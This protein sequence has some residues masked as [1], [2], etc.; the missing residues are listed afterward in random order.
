VT[1]SRGAG[2]WQREATFG[3]FASVTTRVETGTFVG[4]EA[5]YLRRYEGLGLDPFAG[6][7]LFVGPTMFVRLSKALA[8][9]G[10][11]D[12]QVAGRAVAVPGALDLTH[13]ERH[14]ATL[15]LEY[16]F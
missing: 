8:I 2:V 14:Q 13:F 9:S 1:R 4:V 12:V 5:R 15:R 16:N 7:A 10:A 6:E 3:V 11:W